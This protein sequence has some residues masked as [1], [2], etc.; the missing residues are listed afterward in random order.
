MR[1]REN[2]KKRF[3]NEQILREKTL[4]GVSKID[5]QFLQQF[6][7]FVGENYQKQDF[8]YFIG[9]TLGEGSWRWMLGIEALPAAIYA[10]MVLGIPNSPRWL[11]L[12][13]NDEVR[14]ADLLQQLNP[15][16][17]IQALITD[18]KNSVNQNKATQSS[19]F[20]GKYNTPIFLR[21][22]CPN[23]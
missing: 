2:L 13:K 18:I 4:S 6:V 8:D 9:S 19:F 1:N 17:N 12:Q 23:D 3:G 20:S 16:A 10:F 5:G 21:T 14:A 22:N 11:I 7:Q 15:T